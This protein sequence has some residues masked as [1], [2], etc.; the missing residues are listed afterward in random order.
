MRTLLKEKR[1]PRTFKVNKAFPLSSFK[2][3]SKFHIWN[4]ETL[5]SNKFFIFKSFVHYNTIYL[6]YPL[7]CVVFYK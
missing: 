5:S 3:V 1:I 6:I 4:C 2:G 7:K